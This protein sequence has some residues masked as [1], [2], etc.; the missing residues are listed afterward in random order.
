[1]LL[2]MPTIIEPIGAGLAVALIN[3]FI[4]NNPN[5]WVTICGCGKPH[6]EESHEDSSSN[7][8]S[9]NDAEIHIHHM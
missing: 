1:M 8:T 3:K 9:V 7:T 2:I 4:I 6:H 5:L